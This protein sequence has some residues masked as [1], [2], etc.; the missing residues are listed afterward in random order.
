ERVALSPLD[1]QPLQ[2]L[3][4]RRGAE[5]RLEQLLSTL[6]RQR[7]DTQLA[8]VALVTPAVRVLRAIVDEQQDSRFREA[9]NQAVEQGLG[10]SVDPVQV[11]KHQQQRLDLTLAQQQPL[12]GLERLATALGR[13]EDLPGGILHRHFQECQQGRQRRT[14]GLV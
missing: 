10:L 12:A 8:V 1:Q 13:I 6:C 7:I 5:Q 9:V 4:R 14:Q 11:F 3:Q 2:R